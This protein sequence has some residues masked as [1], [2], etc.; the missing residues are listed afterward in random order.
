MYFSVKMELVIKL[1]LL[2]TILMSL[3]YVKRLYSTHDANL[4]LKIL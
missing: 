3:T 1:I 2:L 4:I